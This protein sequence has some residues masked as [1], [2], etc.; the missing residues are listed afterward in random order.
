MDGKSKASC[1][2]GNM[3]GICSRVLQKLHRVDLGQDGETKREGGRNRVDWART[4][5]DEK[6]KI[7]QFGAWGSR[8]PGLVAWV[9]KNG[10][11]QAQATSPLGAAQRWG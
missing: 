1:Q 11:R 8:C 5:G 2:R 10:N 9:V 6:G 4:V 3:A 7:G